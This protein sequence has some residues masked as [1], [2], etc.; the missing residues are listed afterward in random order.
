M[1]EHAVTSGGTVFCTAGLVDRQ[2]GCGPLQRGSRLL[3]VLDIQP[4]YPHQTGP[5]RHV[6]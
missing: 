4:V 6:S 1:C 5:I 3:Q 2:A